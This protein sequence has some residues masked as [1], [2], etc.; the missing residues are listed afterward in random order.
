M[1]GKGLLATAVCAVLTSTALLF[2]FGSSGPAGTVQARVAPEIENAE[3]ITPEPQAMF[4]VSVLVNGYPIQEY[5]ARGCSYVEAREG[6]EYSIRIR[7]PLGV[8]VAVA[9]SV[10]GLNSIDARRSRAYDASKWVIQP[11]SDITVSG[12]QVS[13][14]RLRRFYFTTERESYGAKL[15]QT[16][17]LGVISAVFFREDRPMPIPMPV[18][19]RR[20]SRDE[21]MRREPSDQPIPPSAGTEANESRSASKSAP[22]ASMPSD[23]YAATGI[24]R[25]ARNDVRWLNLDLQ[26]EPAAEITIRYEYRPELVRLGILPRTYEPDPLQR[27]E[28]ATG[29]SDH[30][31]S[32]EP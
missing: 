21:E 12:W 24:G 22:S 20:G 25:S 13:P 19:P 29:F 26:R 2:T 28:R 4:D 32:P 15:G 3:P 18:T 16:R 8:R 6:Q 10:D 30:A 7:N 23:D 14:S 17:N 9:L 27:R 11:Y 1:Y 31:Y 5:S